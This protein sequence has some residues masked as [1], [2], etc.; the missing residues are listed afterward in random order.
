MQLSGLVQSD[1]LS[2]PPS[3]LLHTLFLYML[4][5]AIMDINMPSSSCPLFPVLEDNLMSCFD[6]DHFT[7]VSIGF[8][9]EA[10]DLRYLP[11]R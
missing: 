3:S 5:P 11:P 7:T 9:L 4:L 2:L 10:S 1:W 6:I 8:Q